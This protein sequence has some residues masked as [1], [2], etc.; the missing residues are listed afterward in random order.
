M[1][2]KKLNRSVVPK[3]PYPE[4][5]LQIGEGN[6]LRCFIDWQVDILNE[7]KG[8][9]AG[10]VIAR[11]IDSDFPP[12]L[13]TQNGLYTTF[14]RG[15][16]EQGN[17]RNEQRIITAVTREISIYKEYKEFLAIA[18]NPAIRF[19]VSNTTEAGIAFNENDGFKD[20]P[21]REFPAKLTRF[22][23]ERFRTFGGTKESGFILIPCELID[24]NG[25]ELKRVVL[26][27][28]DLWQLGDEF[29]DW[30][31]TANTFCST[32][33]DRIVTGYPKNESEELTAKL[34][35]EDMFMVAGEFF[36]LFVIQAPESVAEELKIAGSGLNIEVV[37]DLKPY[38]DR[39]VAILNG[40]H[41]ALVP[42]AYLCGFEL[43]KDAVS[44]ADLTEFLDRLLEREIIP[45]LG[46]SE[47]SLREYAANVIKRFKNPYIDHRLLDISLNSMAKFK[48]RILPQFL[49]Y[50]RENNSIPPL[51]SLSLAALIRFY[52]GESG[53][54]SYPLK[55]D[56]CF[57]EQYHDLWTDCTPMTQANAER[58]V[59]EILCLESHWGVMLSDIDG[60]RK[61]MANDLVSIDTK[62]MRAT[63]REYLR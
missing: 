63:L 29:R 21:P 23:H 62:G 60:L 40:C 55:D 27:Y 38:K 4:K 28:V 41:T 15:Y 53:G 45:Y 37:D 49:Q 13:N 24:Y 59:E 12:S 10:V 58:I 2:T 3:E 35:Y 20:T 8:L 7:Q 39:K 31:V 9:D 1:N 30:I 33:V 17:L 46:M 51:M 56:K 5:I 19:I 16:D 43:V 47:K 14:L 22:L 54:N 34:G 52:K 11:P 6:F 36:H 18:R 50:W 48:T 44:D 57:L 42:I 32:L 26:Q 61:K 25:Q